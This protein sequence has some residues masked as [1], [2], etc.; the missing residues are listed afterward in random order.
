MDYWRHGVVFPVYLFLSLASFPLDAEPPALILAEH[1]SGGINLS[2]Y[3][4]SEKYDGVRA[5]WDGKNFISRNGNIFAAPAWFVEGFPHVPMDGELWVARGKFEE[6]VSIVTRHSP[7]KGWR[8]IKYMVFDLPLAAG[9]FDSRIQAMEDIVKATNNDFLFVVSQQKISSEQ[10]LANRLDEIVKAGGEGVMLRYA[11]SSYRGGRSFDLLKLKKSDD[12]E[13]V[14]LRHIAG[15][16]KYRGMLGSIKV[17][18]ARGKIFRIGSG[19]TD[20]MRRDPPAIGS[21]ITFKYQGYYRSGL[22]RFPV[23]WRKHNG[24]PAPGASADAR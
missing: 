8:N 23:F 14:V 6:A 2:D 10:E 12:A 16:G 13:A 18:D 9:D 17:K 5:Y 21:I 11:K 24:E 1:Y 19:F 20:D 4:I 22:P 15:K 7:H 3:W